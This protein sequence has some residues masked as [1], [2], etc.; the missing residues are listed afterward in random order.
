MKIYKNVLLSLGFFLAAPAW[1]ALF[2]FIVHIIIYGIAQPNIPHWITDFVIWPYFIFL[3]IG[4]FFGWKNLKSEK[5]L[6][7][8]HVITIL[9]IIALLIS[10]VIIIVAVG[11]R[12]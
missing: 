3:G 8:G 12:V 4:I 10:L 2:Y 7:I 11:W 6:L 9:G 5:P 1:C